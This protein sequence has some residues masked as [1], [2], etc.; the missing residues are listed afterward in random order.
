MRL[1][2]ERLFNI[3]PGLF[4]SS[5]PGLYPP[6]GVSAVLNVSDTPN[7]FVAGHG[8][9]AVIHLPLIDNTFPGVDWLDLA[10]DLVASLRRRGHGVLVHC[11]MGESR[12]S[13]VLAAYLMRSRGLGVDAALAALVGR[14][15]HAD[16]N[17]RFLAGLRE[18]ERAWRRAA[19]AE[20]G[21]APDPARTEAFRGV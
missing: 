8:L 16:P 15:P 1:D 10:V 14:N 21:A 20:A 19:D 2:A 12:S 4:Q 9:A 17:H 18:A 6:P 13:L 11:D 7:E 3:E 5:R